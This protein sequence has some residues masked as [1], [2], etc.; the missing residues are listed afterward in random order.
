[1]PILPNVSECLT[2][3]STETWVTGFCH[4]GR[5]VPLTIMLLSD[6]DDIGGQK[7]AH[8]QLVMNVGSIPQQRVHHLGVSVLRGSSESCATFLPQKTHTHKK[9]RRRWHNGVLHAAEKISKRLQWRTS[10]Y[11]VTAFLSVSPNE[12]PWISVWEYSIATGDTIML[13]CIP[14]SGVQWRH[15]IQRAASQHHY[16][17]AGRQR[18][19]Q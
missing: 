4:L 10:T 16:D 19:G 15:Q 13:C 12:V 9:T 17:P 7:G 1:M 18:T 3:Q 2:Q 5:Y 11:F 6:R 8:I 14:L